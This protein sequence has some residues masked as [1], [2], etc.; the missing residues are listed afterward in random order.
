MAAG[1]PGS[2]STTTDRTSATSG[3]RSLP[4]PREL[5]RMWPWITPL[6]A[7]AVVNLVVGGFRHFDYHGIHG[8][9][10][11]NYGWLAFAALGG[12]VFGWR[13]ARRPLWVVGLLRPLIA[14]AV[15]FV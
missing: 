1:E 3:A 4:G 13:L 5:V 6:V 12:A 9:S 10:T 7:A 8:F 14:A 11:V 2:P 15:A